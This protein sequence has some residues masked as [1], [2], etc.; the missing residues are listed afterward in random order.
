MYCADEMYL[1]AGRPLPAKE[2]YDAWDLT[3]NGVGSVV[4]LPGGV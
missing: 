2:Y 3:E 4:G 1:H